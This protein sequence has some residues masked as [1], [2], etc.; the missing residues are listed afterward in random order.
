MHIFIFIAFQMPQLPSL[1]QTQDSNYLQYFYLYKINQFIEINIVAKDLWRWSKQKVQRPQPYHYKSMNRNDQYVI[2]WDCRW[3]S[4]C[5]DALMI[6]LPGGRFGT[7][8]NET[9]LSFHL[10]DVV[11]VDRASFMCYFVTFYVII[12]CVILG[13]LCFNVIFSTYET[14]FLPES[15]SHSGDFWGASNTTSNLY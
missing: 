14:L 15:W 9:I 8:N 7:K 13:H 12:Y 2:Y 11:R 3:R 1:T 4:V 10:F 5:F 6:H